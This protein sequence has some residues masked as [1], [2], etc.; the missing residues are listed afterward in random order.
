MISKDQI[1]KIIPSTPEGKQIGDETYWSQVIDAVMEPLL[2]KIATVYDWDFVMKEYSSVTTVA[3]T[4]S[5][6]I[7]GSNYDLRDIVNVRYGSDKKVLSQIRALEADDLLSDG[8]T[9][10]SVQ[11]WYQYGSDAKGY[12]IIT[13]VDTPDTTGDALYIR[14]RKKDIS[15]DDFPDSFSHVFV[16]GILGYLSDSK[17]LRFERSLKQMIKRYRVGG[18]DINLVGMDPHLS[19]GN[20]RRAA[21]NRIG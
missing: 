17:Y 7:S 6:T 11:A 20:S 12:P 4:A 2:D 14:Y 21:Q 19:L 9:L 8:N 16:D 18:R 10:G 5:Y 1:K 3:D 13:L 15:L